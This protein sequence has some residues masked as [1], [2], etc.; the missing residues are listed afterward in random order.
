MDKTFV[1]QL[2]IGTP[3]AIGC[4]AYRKKKEKPRKRPF[5]KTEDEIWCEWVRDSKP[6]TLETPIS[7]IFVGWKQG[8]NGWAFY[9]QG[10]GMVFEPS[11]PGTFLVRFRRAAGAPEELAFPEDCSVSLEKV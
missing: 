3:I 6:G 8:L 9:E 7:G 10:Y 2:M 1:K 4:C 11:G 5:Y